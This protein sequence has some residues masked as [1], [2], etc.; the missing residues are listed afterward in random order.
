MFHESVSIPAPN[1]ITDVG[2]LSP[3]GTAGQGGSVF[4]WEETDFD[5]VNDSIYSFAFFT[6]E[7]PSSAR[8]VRGGFWNDNYPFLLSSCRDN[9]DFFASNEYH[10]VGFRVASIPEPT[11]CTLALAALCLVV[12]RRRS[13]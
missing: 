7:P 9:F 3:Y 13:F 4:E 1:D 8:G 11:T 5:L 10:F 6:E 2:I 12:G